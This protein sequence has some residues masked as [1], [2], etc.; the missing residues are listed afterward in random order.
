MCTRP[1]ES[2]SSQG[3]ITQPQIV[4]I[5]RV[6]TKIKAYLSVN[7]ELNNDHYD[8]SLFVEQEEKL[9]IFDEIYF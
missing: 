7:G 6:L 9:G 4:V 2:L 8:I 3:H 5:G 1:P